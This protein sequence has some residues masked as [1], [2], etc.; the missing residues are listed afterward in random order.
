MLGPKQIPDAAHDVSQLSRSN[1]RAAECEQ[2]P[3]DR[4]AIEKLEWIAK[5][6]ADGQVELPRDLPLGS[7]R[8]VVDL[9]RRRRRQNLVAHIARCIAVDILKTGDSAKEK[10]P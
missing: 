2:L 7:L 4:S 1:T 3:A 9:V 5:L 6:V 8:D 10:K